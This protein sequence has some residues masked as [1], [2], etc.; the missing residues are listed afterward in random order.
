MWIVGDARLKWHQQWQA[1]HDESFPAIVAVVA[2]AATFFST[3]LI[4]IALALKFHSWAVSSMQH[5][6]FILLCTSAALICYV[7]VSTFDKKKSPPP[8]KLTKNLHGTTWPSHLQFASYATYWTPMGQSGIQHM[9]VWQFL[10]Y[11]IIMGEKSVGPHYLFIWEASSCIV[12]LKPS[13]IY[14]GKTELN[15]VIFQWT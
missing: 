13:Y 6:L 12:P 1:S 10:S 11:I 4:F 5:R 7:L 9:W 2:L 3:T 14:Y 15:S 8:Q